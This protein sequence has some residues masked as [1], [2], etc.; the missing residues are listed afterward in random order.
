MFGSNFVEIGIGL[1][2]LFVL[3]SLMCSHATETIS[4]RLN[5]RSRFLED[6]IR[7]LL[8]DVAMADRVYR[9]PLIKGLG[10][11]IPFGPGSFLFRAARLLSLHRR[12]DRELDV[13]SKPSYIPSHLFA[14]ALVDTILLSRRYP[15]C[16]ALCKALGDHKDTAVKRLAGR[17]EAAILEEPDVFAA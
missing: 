12:M 16:G 5:W 9:H 2:L 15:P 1:S 6:G 3:M 8:Q 4:R 10:R 14:R 13:W 11:K 7:E 17:I